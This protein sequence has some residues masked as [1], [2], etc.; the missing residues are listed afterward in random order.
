MLIQRTLTAKKLSVALLLFLLAGCTSRPNV[1]VQDEN[2]AQWL[3]KAKQYE[4]TLPNDHPDRTENILAISASMR[5]AINTHFA[6]LPRSLIAERMANWLMAEDGHHMIYDIN[7]NH[8]PSQAFEE[9]RGNCLSFTILLT[10]M[11]AEL[12]VELKYNE[13]QL[14]DVW[15][16]DENENNGLV[17]YRHIN[18]IRETRNQKF[19]FDLAMDE[20]DLDYPQRIIPTRN[21]VALLHNNRAIESF[22]KKDK[23][24]TMH[25]I[26]LAVSQNP[27]N[28]DIFVN[29]GAILKFFGRRE[30]ATETLLHALELDNN[31]SIAATKLERWYRADGNKVKSRKYQRL[32]R[33]SHARNPY[34][35]FS[36]AQRYFESGEYKTARRY[37]RRAKR[38]YKEDSRF[39]LLS[40]HIERKFDNYTKALKELQIAY[41]LAKSSEQREKYLAQAKELAHVMKKIIADRTPVTTS[42][43]N[44]VLRD[45]SLPR[46]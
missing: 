11:A 35:Q 9:R 23:E 43:T 39:F 42:N 44:T 14:P 17:L 21:A 36:Q 40:S 16:Q 31:S 29:L 3:V 4:Q 10:T 34:F 32:A 15:N 37:I 27:E 28:P 19:V 38:L 45:Y 25:Y 41:G 5:D 7:A 2:L 26:R 6:S 20:Y 46:L 22:Q 30:L 33:S 1:T 24:Q 18:A 8:H 13:V 12:D